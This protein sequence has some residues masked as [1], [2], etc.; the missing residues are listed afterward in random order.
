MTADALAAW[1]H[2]RNQIDWAFAVGE[3]PA[4]VEAAVDGLGIWRRVGD[5]TRIRLEATDCSRRWLSRAQTLLVGAPSPAR[6]WRSG[7]GLSLACLRFRSDRATPPPRVAGGQE[8]YALTPHPQ[9][10]F[11]RCLR[12]SADPRVPLASRAAKACLDV[13]PAGI[14]PAPCRPSV[15]RTTP[16]ARQT[17]LPWPPSSSARPIGGRPEPVTE[18]EAVPHLSSALPPP[19][20]AAH[21]AGCHRPPGCRREA[22]CRAPLARPS[23]LARSSFCGQGR[24]RPP[25]QP[26]AKRPKIFRFVMNVC[27]EPARPA[28]RAKWYG[29]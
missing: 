20:A 18:Y 5:A 25:P 1:C 23:G 2:V 7:S 3:T 28:T 27:V 6:F 29:L 21:R 15:T 24:A 19:D 11:G 10:D 8:R 9:R 4:P 17:W 14:R 26:S 13:C 12:E 22:S 16:L